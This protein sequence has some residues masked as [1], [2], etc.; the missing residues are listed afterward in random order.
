MPQPR[1]P[2]GN[3]A[4]IA[5]LLHHIRL[6]AGVLESSLAHTTG[7][8]ISYVRDILAGRRFP[9]RTFTTR[10][11]RVCGADPLVLLMVWQDE[12]DRRQRHHPRF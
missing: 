7:T 1:K 11:A 4:H 5:H 6:Y 3:L 2:G 10:Y 8:D 12:H 9:S